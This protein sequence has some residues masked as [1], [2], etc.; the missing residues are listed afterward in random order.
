VASRLEEVA[1]PLCVHISLH[2]SL[3]RRQRLGVAGSGDTGAYMH[4]LA[5]FL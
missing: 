3:V 2:G 1:K 5:L 4:G